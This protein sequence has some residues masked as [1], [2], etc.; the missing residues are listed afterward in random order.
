[1]AMRIVDKSNIET[2]SKRTRNQAGYLVLPDCVIARAG[3][4]QYSDVTC[5]DG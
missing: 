2:K 3:I 1:M 5:E 4:L